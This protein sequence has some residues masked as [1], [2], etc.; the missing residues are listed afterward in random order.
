MNFMKETI[1]CVAFSN[2]EPG[3]TN[4]TFVDCISVNVTKEHIKSATVSDTQKELK[5]VFS[6]KNSVAF[7]FTPI[8]SGSFKCGSF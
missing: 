2:S 1:R 3:Q 5:P 8:P 7:S 6:P 4:K